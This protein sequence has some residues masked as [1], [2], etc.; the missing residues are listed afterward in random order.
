MNVII[1]PVRTLVGFFSLG[2]G[3]KSCLGGMKLA[4]GHE[5]VECKSENKLRG[6]QQL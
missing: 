1:K 3:F 4:S 2:D 6:L 5:D